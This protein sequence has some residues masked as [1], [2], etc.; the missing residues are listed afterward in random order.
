MEWKLQLSKEHNEWPETENL[1]G[2][3]LKSLL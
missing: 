2:H 1:G 3:I